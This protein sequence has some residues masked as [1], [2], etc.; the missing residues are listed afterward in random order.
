MKTKLKMKT[1]NKHVFLIVCIWVVHV[2]AKIVNETTNHR[3]VE[4]I[5]RRQ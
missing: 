2:K 1:M 4:N 5:I 3:F